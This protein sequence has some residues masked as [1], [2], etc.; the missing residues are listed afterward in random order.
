M[1]LANASLECGIKT[2]AHSFQE[3]RV[4]R[5]TWVHIALQQFQV[6]FQSLFTGACWGPQEFGIDPC[7]HLVQGDQFPP[8]RGSGTL[9]EAWV[10]C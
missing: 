2:T 6:A 9:P 1:K 4:S 10:A 7:L 3:C 8:S 5:S